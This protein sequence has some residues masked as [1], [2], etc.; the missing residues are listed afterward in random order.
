MMTDV[1]APQTIIQ[2]DSQLIERIL[3]GEAGAWDVLLLRYSNLIYTV[4]RRYGLQETDCY[5]VYQNVCIAL[6]E[7]LASL[8]DHDRIGPWLLTVAGRIS[9]R[10][11][12]RR[13]QNTQRTTPLPDE[14]WGYSD[15]NY[16]TADPSPDAIVLRQ[17][18]ADAL[19]CALDQLPERCR[20]LLWH[21]Y[22]E[23]DTP[24]YAAIGEHLGL[25]VGSIGPI[26]GR[27]LENLRKLLEKDGAGVY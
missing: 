20:T 18:T 9:W 19:R 5:D 12:L 22:F 27:C 17:E 10:A 24:S 13:R 2:T 3:A 7:G 16:A 11:V 26:R 21:L 4:P 15:K 14:E 1:S 6:W 8:R 25:A 23:S